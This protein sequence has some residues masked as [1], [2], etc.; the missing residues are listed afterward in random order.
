[1]VDDTLFLGFNV[2]SKIVV[3]IFRF[4]MCLCC[5]SDST[6]GRRCVPCLV[7]NFT[8]AYVGIK[9]SHLHFIIKSISSLILR[10]FVISSSKFLVT[11]NV[12][13]PCFFQRTLKVLIR[14]YNFV[15]KT[16]FRSFLSSFLIT[17]YDTFWTH[18]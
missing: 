14:A 13:P 10:C 3:L 17:Q 9:P 18:P 12:S 11:F 15:V 7:A 1:M 16:G 5:S 4:S 2:V 6:Y 8:N